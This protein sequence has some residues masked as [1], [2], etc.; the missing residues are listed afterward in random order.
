LI[1]TLAAADPFAPSAGF[2][3]RRW[4]RERLAHAVGRLTLAPS[5]SHPELLA[6]IKGSEGLEMRATP[7]NLFVS[8]IKAVAWYCALID[9]GLFAVLAIASAIG[10]LP[11]S[12]RPGPGW[13]QA[14]IPTI[15]ELGFYLNFC[16]FLLGPFCLIW[17][18]ILGMF[19]VGLNWL[20]APRFVVVLLGSIAGAYISLIGAAATGWYI[21]IAA[22]PVYV[23]GIF[24]LVFGAVLLP[25]L[26]QRKE[27]ERG[28]ASW[29]GIVALTTMLIFVSV[30]P[31]LP[32]RDAQ[33]LEVRVMRL[34]SGPDTPPEEW[35]SLNKEQVAFLRSLGLHGKLHGGIQSYSGTSD[36]PHAKAIVI[37]TEPI[38]RRVELRQP[39]R[40]TVMYVQVGD[41]WKVFPEN[42]PTIKKKIL[43]QPAPDGPTR[44]QFDVEPKVGKSVSTF[45]WYPPIESR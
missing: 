41:S 20:R 2:A 35:T 17:G 36:L 44:I 37:A 14:H 4:R 45:T 11:Y 38:N 6:F 31:Q 16:V 5:F 19:A 29:M 23:A 33:E 43:L 27:G 42:A 30:F 40:T 12:D 28:W 24:G 22:F 8:I 15:T 7:C 34:V 10:Y 13:H 1:G 21:A 18:A 32:R 39:K 26:S 3:H 9:G 25:R